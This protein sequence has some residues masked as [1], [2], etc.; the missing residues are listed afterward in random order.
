MQRFID[1]LYD[2][3]VFIDSLDQFVR[4]MS[5]ADVRKSLVQTVLKITIPGVPDFYQGAHRWLRTL[6]DPDNREPVDFSTLDTDLLTCAELSAQDAVTRV[7]DGLVKLWVTSRT[8]SLRRAHA[9][10]APE[11]PY[12]PLETDGPSASTVLAFQRGRDIVV[13]VPTRTVDR[14][15]DG[16]LIVLPP[17]QWRDRLSGHI[18]SGGVQAVTPLWDPLPVA[19]LERDRS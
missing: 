11:A 10:L 15:W 4:S 18:V 1:G 2:D 7:Q 17:G 9:D 8:L 12:E 16:T 13:S 19:L 6:C 3:A 5:P 14:N